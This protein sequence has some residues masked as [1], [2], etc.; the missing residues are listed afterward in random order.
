MNCQERKG[1]L[2]TNVTTQT[3]C[4]RGPDALVP[5][6]CERMRHFVVSLR[7]AAQLTDLYALAMFSLVAL[8]L[9][10]IH[11]VRGSK[12]ISE[13]LFFSYYTA[14]LNT[15]ILGGGRGGFYDA[16]HAIPYLV[17]GGPGVFGV[18]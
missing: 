5:N 14:G 6:P 15:L 8:F 16:R 1:F 2:Y 13:E 11:R 4:Q 7:L 3:R 18:S 12:R 17:F 9:H 10:E